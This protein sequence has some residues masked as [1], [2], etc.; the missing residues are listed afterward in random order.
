MAAELTSAK[1]PRIILSNLPA[2]EKDKIFDFLVQ[3]N[4]EFI[5]DRGTKGYVA[6]VRV[7]KDT[8]PK[9]QPPAQKRVP[10]ASKPQFDT[11]STASQRTAGNMKSGNSGPPGTQLTDVFKQNDASMTANLHGTYRRKYTRF[12]A[13]IPTKMTERPKLL[14]KPKLLTLIDEVYQARFKA[15]ALILHNNAKRAMTSTGDSGKDNKELVHFPRYVIEILKKKLGMRT[16]VSPNCWNLVHSVHS[17]RESD[18]SIDLFARFL[19]ESYGSLDLLFFLYMR[20]HAERFVSALKLDA[21]ERGFQKDGA[22]VLCNA[23]VNDHHAVELLNTVMPTQEHIMAKVLERLS[24]GEASPDGMLRDAGSWEGG[25]GEGPSVHGAYEVDVDKLLAVACE[26]F[27]D[28]NADRQALKK[29]D[30]L[31][32]TF[33]DNPLDDTDEEGGSPETKSQTVR[34]D[35][36]ERVATEAKSV[37]R[38]L[39][40]NLKSMGQPDVKPDEVQQW[41]IQVARRRVA[42]ATS[43]TGPNFGATSNDEDSPMPYT[44][45][46]DEVKEAWQGLGLEADVPL[47]LPTP[48]DF[49]EDLEG[50]VH[51]VLVMV[52]DQTVGQAVERHLK[53]SSD[54]K[55]GITKMPNSLPTRHKLASE[56][57]RIADSLMEA[58]VNQDFPTW[59]KHL[60][61]R[62]LNV[63]SPVVKSQKSKERETFDALH[64]TLQEILHGQVDSESISS[65]ARSILTTSALQRRL[66]KMVAEALPNMLAELKKLIAAQE[67]EA[68]KKKNEPELPQDS[69][70]EV[71]SRS[72][73]G[74]S[75]QDE[76]EAVETPDGEGSNKAPPSVSRQVS[77]DQVG[78]AEQ[79]KTADSGATTP[80]AGSR[81]PRATSAVDTPRALSERSADP[82]S[83][84]GAGESVGEAEAADAAPAEA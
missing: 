40:K 22:H 38:A 9:Q 26:E 43:P 62:P 15:D 76:K 53:D 67:A 7:E 55:R 82:Q 41:A 84:G 33:F 6:T 5:C 1:V 49:E 28:K 39:V 10:L 74:V 11:A 75:F 48:K 65:I 73:S 31:Y 21:G 2:A 71:L 3:N 8:K 16:L 63:R 20:S 57:T 56:L 25:E 35:T 64:G 46:A 54:A 68:K 29:K 24:M 14:T 13:G 69:Q 42:G 81:S 79:P 80:R 60:G 18:V 50:S 19:E 61:V 58:L 70:Q 36:E 34:T 78:E 32:D 66:S 30:P 77:S 12:T 23:R 52:A 27:H 45:N 37:A 17:Y 83:S 44:V 72:P 51:S 4:V 47:N 59:Q